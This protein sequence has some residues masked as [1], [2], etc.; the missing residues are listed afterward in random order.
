V[1]IN[2]LYTTN[3]R[4]EIDSS[5]SALAP[6]QCPSSL[7]VNGTVVLL[8]LLALLARSDLL[9]LHSLTSSDP[10]H[11]IRPSWTTAIPTRGPTPTPERQ[12]SH[13]GVDW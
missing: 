9:G 13:S 12:A 8:A 3:D 1:L 11:S 2:T 4:E 7:R 5:Y 10:L 6:K